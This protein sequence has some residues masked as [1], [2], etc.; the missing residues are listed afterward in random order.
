M[1]L[2]DHAQQMHNKCTTNAQQMHN[3]ENR[4]LNQIHHTKNSL[5]SVDYTQKADVIEGAELSAL[6][7][8][9][10]FFNPFKPKQILLK[11]FGLLI[12]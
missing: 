4:K 7:F 10:F 5:I 11:F 3:K 6:F 9:S 2:S 1:N 8:Q 12:L